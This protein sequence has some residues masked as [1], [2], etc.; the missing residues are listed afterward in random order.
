MSVTDRRWARDLSQAAR[1]RAVWA[2]FA[3]SVAILLGSLSPAY[4]PQAS[5]IWDWLPRS[6]FGLEV[7]RW[8]GTVLTLVGL[9]LL[10]ES[11]FRLRPSNRRRRGRPMLRNWAVLAII[12]APLLIGPPVFSH[13]AYSYVAHGWLLHNGLNPYAVGPGVLP[14]YFVDQV[15]WV[16]RETPAPY[17][18][19]ALQISHGLVVLA[20]F[21]PLLAT[22]VH[23]I[24]ALVGVGLIGYLTPRIAAKVGVS[25]S[26]A[27]WFATLNPILVID[28]VGGAHNDSLMTGLMVLGIWV[29]MRYR[30]VVVGA[31]IVGMAAAVKQPALLTAV[32]L[33]FIVRP[34]TSWQPKP[35]AWAFVRSVG[36]LVV[37]V[38]A[39]VG[40]TFA[41]GLGFGWL[42]AVD[43]PGMVDTFSP[44]VL[45]GRVLEF[46][47]TLAGHPELGA[48]AFSIV[49][50]IGV[51]AIVVGM[52]WLAVLYLGRRPIRFVSWS[53]IWFSICAPALHS[54]YL[55]WGG[56]LLP[57]TH[58]SR[59]MLRAAIVAT[60]A[61]LG[62]NAM[63]FGLRNGLWVVMLSL[64]VA[65]YWTI[66]THELSLP[67]DEHDDE[68]SR[69]IPV[70]QG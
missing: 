5:P 24:P 11:W 31:I 8:S 32:A 13:D 58:P 19:L 30:T 54:W 56:V 47:F 52:V 39:F 53:L 27:S 1:S 46:P 67:L 48:L 59:R 12:S 18:P 14:G 7:L 61:L 33:P 64:L 55:L 23:R 60:V 44:V 42:G 15:A 70:G 65:I 43:V 40:I 69:D 28:F 66:H 21:D 25:R 26:T 9:A 29:T 57:M 10:I 4:L 35:L 17:G 2:G 68:V 36:S 45:I 37:A 50:K 22:L 38:A 3:G 62:Y 6:A 34:W 16:W 49:R 63:N 51:V 41:T 20:G